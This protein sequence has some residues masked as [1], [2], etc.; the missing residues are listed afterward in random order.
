MSFFLY[1]FVSHT[2]YSDS[3]AYMVCLAYKD[4]KRHKDKKGTKIK[5]GTLN[6]K[7]KEKVFSSPPQKKYF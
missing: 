5:K 6:T 2:A 3:D 7:I 1:I 4:K